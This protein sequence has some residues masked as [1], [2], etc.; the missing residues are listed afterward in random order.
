MTEYDNPTAEAI[1]LWQE[2][3]GVT[4]E[5]TSFTM[6]NYHHRSEFEHLR[7]ALDL[8]P[9]EITANLL[10]GSYARAHFR[11]THISQ[12][13]L[14]AD[15]AGVLELLEKPRRLMTI[16]ERPEIVE[17]R[18]Q[19]IANVAQALEMYDASDRDDI[20][21]LL[22]NHDDMAFLRRDALRSM[23]NLSVHQF[24]DGDPE[25]ATVRPVYYRFVHQWFNINS[26]LDFAASQAPGVSLNLIRDPND[27]QSYFCFA[28]RNGGR[29]FVLSDVPQNAHPMQ[30]ML[31]RR[32]DKE[33]DRRISRNWF[34]YDLM[35]L[36]YN[37]EDGKLYFDRSEQ[38]ALVVGQSKALPLRPIS[39]LGAPETV[40]IAMMFGLIVDRFWR[41]GHTEKY[42]S[43]TAEMI[44]VQDKMIAAAAKSGLPVKG[45]ATIDAKPLTVDAVM[46]PDE[47]ALEGYGKRTDMSNRWL[48]ERYGHLV[49]DESLN[50]I[51][52]PERRHQ[53][54]L[55]SGEVSDSR[56]REEARR[57]P[58]DNRTVSVVNLEKLP[59]TTFGSQEKLE[60]DRLFVAR[61]NYAVQIDALA[62]NEFEKRKDEVR[63]WYRSKVDANIETLKSWVGDYVLW[64]EDNDSNSRFAGKRYYP[65]H[66]SSGRDRE[67]CIRA[68][69]YPWELDDSH[70]RSTNL[71]FGSYYVGGW[72]KGGA[73]CAVNDTKASYA[74]VFCPSNAREVA[75]VAGCAEEELPD[76]LRHYDLNGGKQGNHLLDR[77]DPA[78]WVIH[79]PWRELDLRVGIFLSK[80][81][82]AKLCSKG[83]HPPYWIENGYKENIR[84]EWRKD[85][86]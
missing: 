1:D 59:S 26:M 22:A 38:K 63:R 3:I 68:F 43:Y 74:F 17:R 11:N 70:E 35:G 7:E 66:G 86:S 37:E 53:L 15:T 13:K 72:G 47:A 49:T 2:I 51:G 73:L 81:G 65:F 8:D 52:S 30:P 85:R 84:Q 67:R 12:A 60:A 5:T 6:G 75:V 48:E 41:R 76:V 32:P 19:F 71:G 29:L 55:S 23:A 33:M 46:N 34:P 16:L 56:T 36:A 80:R 78:E 20:K 44:R 62:R 83:V 4:P 54:A 58:G 50:L 31:S 42:L 45:Y 10:L 27:Y 82:F 18:D 39:K 14:L 9:T 61:Y 28:I 79:D 25:P 21:T 69:A 57:F 40:W 24:L 77:I 64:V